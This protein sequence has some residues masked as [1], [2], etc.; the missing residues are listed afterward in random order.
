MA[1]YLRFMQNYWNE[2]YA[3][4]KC[5]WGL[6]PS[7]TAVTALELFRRKGVGKILVPGS[8]YG[9]NSKLFSEA[10][11]AVTGIEISD[12]ATAIARKYDPRSTFICASFLDLQLE[13]ASYD[14]IYCFNVLHL[15]RQAERKLFIE[16]SH[17][18]LRE[19]GIAFFTVFSDKEKSFGKGEKIEE[20]TFESKPSRPVHYFSE[21][22]LNNHFNIFTV[23]EAGIAEDHENHGE[24]GPH[25][26]L[27]RYIAAEKI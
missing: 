6:S 13:K 10:G 12:E 22:D 15:F 8:G 14:A 16:R 26:H 23:H 9:R 17:F 7:T 11:L 3:S 24:E 27:V 18:L 21:Q 4:E 5:I 1:D 19:N 20:N 2:R 25:I